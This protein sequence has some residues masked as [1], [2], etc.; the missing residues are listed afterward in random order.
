MC[1]ALSGPGTGLRVG[2]V[3]MRRCGGTVL[4][5]SGGVMAAPG[6]IAG[7]R[8]FVR[9]GATWVGF[10]EKPKSFTHSSFLGLDLPGLCKKS[11]R[12][13]L[14]LSGPFAQKDAFEGAVSDAGSIP[15]AVYVY[16]THPFFQ[17]SRSFRRF[18][19]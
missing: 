1:M 19:D 9:N 14:D 2:S 17:C 16:G 18:F 10:D 13:D 8:N 7:D 12:K 15:V 3:A 5:L 11:G 6:S 4:L